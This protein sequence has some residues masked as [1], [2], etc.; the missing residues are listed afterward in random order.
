M[1]VILFSSHKYLQLKPM[2]LK[3]S[4]NMGVFMRKDIKKKFANKQYRYS[5]LFGKTLRLNLNILQYLDSYKD[6]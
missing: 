6:E 2:T 4:I 1:T 5:L 3:S